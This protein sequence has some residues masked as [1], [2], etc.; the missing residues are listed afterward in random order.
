MKRTI[1]TLLATVMMTVGASAQ[2]TER[3]DREEILTLYVDTE[4]T[5]SLYNFW[6]TYVQVH[7]K[8]EVA[9]RNLFDVSEK[10]VYRRINTTKDWKGCEEYRKQL[11]VVGRMEKAIPDT[12]TFYYCA[13]EGS[14][15]P[16]EEAKLAKEH[17]ILTLYMHHDAYA[18]S[19]IATLPVDVLACDYERWI[20]HLIPKSDT[21]RINQLLT[22]YYESGQYPEETL[23]YHF[24]EL[25]GME[26]GAVYCGAHEGDIIGKLILQR[27]LGVHQDKVLYD[28]NAA[29]VPGYVK[30]VFGQIGIPYDKA[31]YEQG[32]ENQIEKQRAIMCYIF[33]HSK[34]PVY[35]SAHNMQGY[36]L[37]YGLPDELKARLYNEGLTIRYSPKPYDN[38]AVKRRNI[39]QRYRLEY[40]RMPFHPK[41]KDTQLFSFSAEAYAM[42]YMRLLHDQLP[43]YKKHNR[44]RYQWLHDIFT[45]I[46]ERLDKENFDVDE[47]KGYLK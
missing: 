47:F 8:D 41:M 18:D 20:Q 22:R 7:P 21:V 32:Y 17:N 14:Y 13:Y 4:K 10:K 37:G 46:I 40:L 44:E 19:A 31:W 35:L 38:M 2:Q 11:N 42:N 26:T 1:F 43:Y 3:I 9:W 34:R 6:N 27:V 33:D 23:Q 24:N 29:M 28:E 12:Y 15:L 39:E 45:D 5:D 16:E 25:Q 36:V 30:D